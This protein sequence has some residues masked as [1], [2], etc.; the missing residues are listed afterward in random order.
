MGRAILKATLGGPPSPKRQETPPW[1]KSL[2]SSHAE[3]FLRDSSMVVEARLHF[4]SK[5]S[6]TFTED[7][8]HDLSGIF[9]KLA[10]SA[11]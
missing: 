10:V 3:A 9:K 11:S 8:N 7:S 1:F 4:F 2:K 5:H 6:Y